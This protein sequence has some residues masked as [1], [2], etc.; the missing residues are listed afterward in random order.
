MSGDP[1]QR[2]VSLAEAAERI[3]DRG[4]ILLP[5]PPAQPVGLLEELGKRERFAGLTL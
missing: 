4:D 2:R 5:L 3:G 1:L